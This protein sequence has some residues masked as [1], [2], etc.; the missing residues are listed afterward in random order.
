VR[1]G[2][3]R[4]LELL[5]RGRGR[6]I[7][8]AGVRSASQRRAG[9]DE[10]PGLRSGGIEF[11]MRANGQT[12]KGMAQSEETYAFMQDAFEQSVGVQLPDPET[13]PMR[14]GRRG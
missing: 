14:G 8:G 1:L 5:S 3:Q 6:I 9:S 10:Q 2:R 11:F 4:R 12:M 7:L 13:K